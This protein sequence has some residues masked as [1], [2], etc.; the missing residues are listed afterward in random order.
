MAAYNLVGISLPGPGDLQCN[1]KAYHAPFREV[2]HE[3]YI[4]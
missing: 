3:H 4:N 1:M 2:T